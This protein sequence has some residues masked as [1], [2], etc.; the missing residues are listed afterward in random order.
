MP[1]KN[2]KDKDLN[3]DFEESK[4]KDLKDPNVPPCL[5]WTIDDVCNFFEKDLKLPEYKVKTHYRDNILQKL[6]KYSNNYL[7]PQSKHY[8]QIK[9]TEDV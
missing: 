3:K 2:A 7:F 1:S 6:I 8:N 5:Y 4:F 9:S